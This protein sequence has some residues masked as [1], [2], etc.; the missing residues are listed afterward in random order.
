MFNNIH[1]IQ[2]HINIGRNI[3]I[4]LLKP[5]E[6][7]ALQYISKIIPADIHNEI[8]NTQPE[9]YELLRRAT[10]NYMMPFALPFLKV[11]ISSIGGNNFDDDKMKKADWWDLRDYALSA[12]KI[13]DNTLS[14]LVA[15]LQKTALSSKLTLFDKDYDA[16]NLLFQSPTDFEQIYDI[17]NSWFVFQKLLPN[18]E[19]VWLLYLR[20]RLKTCTIA[21]LLQ[22][23]EAKKLLR[24]IVGYY[25]LAESIALSGIV[26][27][28]SGIVLQWEQLPWQKSAVI[29]RK[30]LNHLA[31]KYTD[32]ANQLFALLLDYLRNNTDK[33]PCYEYSSEIPYRKTIAKKSGLYF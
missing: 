27:T 9:A 6:Q 23:E 1:E 18:M 16:T 25:T 19:V 12:I 20:G 17:G 32:K 29:D 3:D 26:F 14:S 28:T 24:Q 31:E 4:E 2:E 15:K 11:H 30:E 8:Q 5:Y 7:E 21:D 22:D 13:A 10:A 33:F